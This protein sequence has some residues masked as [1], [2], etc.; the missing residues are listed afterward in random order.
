M[1]RKSK[2]KKTNRH[3]S[4]YSAVVMSRERLLRL[5]RFTDKY[6]KES[7]RIA[8]TPSISKVMEEAGR[9][10]LVKFLSDGEVGVSD[11]AS[12]I[13]RRQGQQNLARMWRR[14]KHEE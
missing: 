1:K 12:T 2:K 8:T 10:E 13:L 11:A 6:S 14:L 5:P 3:P 4:K 7:K 9:D